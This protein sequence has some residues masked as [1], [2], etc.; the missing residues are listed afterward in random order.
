MPASGPFV[1]FKEGEDIVR[2]SGLYLK[3][4]EDGEVIVLENK[5]P[6]EHSATELSEKNVDDEYFVIDIKPAQPKQST[7]TEHEEKVESIPTHK[8]EELPVAKTIEL[9]VE[10]SIPSI[11]EI[12][13]EPLTKNTSE[14]KTE[15]SVQSTPEVKI[16]KSDQ[17]T[18]ELTKV[19][20][21]QMSNILQDK[22]DEIIKPAD[23]AVIDAMVQSIGSIKQTKSSRFNG[24]NKNL[25][26][27]CE[28]LL[29]CITCCTRSRKHTNG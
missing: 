17:P 25:K 11:S 19:I 13:I 21:T 5:S 28:K 2:T 15:T 26:A 23:E 7:E 12:K 8:T 16:E 20:K 1:E 4:Y 14:V 24:F 27:C 29:S 6:S 22:I 18:I 9:A 10:Q 3:A